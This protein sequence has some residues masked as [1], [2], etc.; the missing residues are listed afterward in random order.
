MTAAENAPA[1]LAEAGRPAIPPRTK[2]VGSAA[3]HG[4]AI[5]GEQIAGDQK[6]RRHA[7]TQQRALRYV[8]G[9]HH[10]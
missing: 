9:D 8:T 2:A 5:A 7:Q 3:P 10:D 4:R 1:S 6:G